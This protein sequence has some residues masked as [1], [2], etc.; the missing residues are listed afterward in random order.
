MAK[1]CYCY[2]ILH[3]LPTKITDDKILISGINKIKKGIC[4]DFS[5]FE[6][7]LAGVEKFCKKC[8]LQFEDSKNIIFYKPIRIRKSL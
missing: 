4:M 1:R 6:S 8:K 5:Y 7:A 2:E 3:D